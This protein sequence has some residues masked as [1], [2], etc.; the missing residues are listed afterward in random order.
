MTSIKLFNYWG[1]F[2][3]W[4]ALVA[5]MTGCASSPNKDG[6]T[7]LDATERQSANY[8]TTDK[9]RERDSDTSKVDLLKYK[10]SF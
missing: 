3:L 1:Q 7:A 5:V 6:L 4:L 2:V 9:N 8:G 10:T